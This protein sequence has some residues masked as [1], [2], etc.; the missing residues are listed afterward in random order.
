MARPISY[1]TLAEAFAPCRVSLPRAVLEAAA[2]YGVLLLGSTALSHLG[3]SMPLA[4][5]FLLALGELWL[6]GWPAWRLYRLAG[7]RWWVRA[8]K[9]TVRA[10]LLSFLLGLT[11]AFLYAAIAGWTAV[12]ARQ[13]AG[14]VFGLA[15]MFVPFRA[16]VLV[17]GWLSRRV[18]RRLRW[19]LMASN[20]A[21]VVL[22]FA[23]M[24]AVAS[25]V[26]ATLLISALQPDQRRMALWIA[27]HTPHT[28]TAIDRRAGQ[29]MLNRIE[30][31]TVL[32]G[33][34]PYLA[35]LIPR[36][37]A[38]TRVTLSDLNG[39]T[40]AQAWRLGGEPNRFARQDS[41]LKQPRSWFS[42]YRRRIQNRASFPV[43]PL[44]RNG[45]VLASAPILAAGGR[46][47]GVVAVQAPSI[48]VSQV[49]FL[50]ISLFGAG[51]IILIVATALPVLA[52]SALLSY[53]V[54]RSLTRELESVSRVT[55]AIAAGD[56]T[57]RAPR[58]P[59]N[60]LGSLS[61]NVN[62]MAAHLT[63]AM[64]ELRQA[65]TQA[66]EALRTRQQL[67]AS[68]SHELRTP[69]AVLRAH[70]DT[71]AMHP[72]AVA[73]AGAHDD[74]WEVSLPQRTLQALQH[75]TERL[76]SLIDDLFALSRAEAG[77]LEVHL[78]PTDVTALVDEVAT[79]MRPLAQ[80]EGMVTLLVEPTGK[81]P[82]VAAD[83]DRLRQILAN[84][85]RN[86]VRHTP[87]GGIVVLS[88]TADAD[89]VVLSVADTG[90][91]IAADHLPHIFERFYRV[92]EAR[93]RDIGGSGLGLAIVREFV[94]L[95]G[96]RV[97][98]ESAPDEGS[99]FSVYLRAVLS[100]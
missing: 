100:A 9:G 80:R 89:W 37:F 60:E 90:E 17:Y 19:Q 24:A 14:A 79:L 76:N 74:E 46:S 20:V 84:L 30:Q 13:A 28:G 32:V 5:G 91:G 66:E 3:G 18:R 2:G 95:M 96:G 21:V 56:L 64:G 31:G 16:A 99:R 61:E 54:A 78:E 67:V 85:V 15:F 33:G 42:I 38:P 72:A 6:V 48:G 92:D 43:Q 98:V 59:G 23:T 65:R 87:E 52:I 68:I 29:T 77:G 45:E 7:G 27:G 97:A 70:L 8:A 53:L 41:L 58:G 55:T 47:I 81:V 11:G 71:L 36:A 35:G 39:K 75:E 40:L 26:V 22:T 69:L 57:Q 49:Q 4:A 12:A 62:R 10:V 51:T 93:S 50:A 1:P 25:L 82:P 86:A 73:P 83:G 44:I 88:V 34:E 63:T 94:E